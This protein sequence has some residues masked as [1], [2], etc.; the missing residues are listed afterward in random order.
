MGKHKTV[1]SACTYN[2]R[3]I[4]SQQC[5]H[6]SLKTD[7]DIETGRKNCLWLMAFVGPGSGICTAAA[8]AAA[9][10]SPSPPPPLTPPPP[11]PIRPVSCG[12]NE[13]DTDLTFLSKSR[14]DPPPPPLPA[15]E[16]E[17]GG[18]SAGAKEK[19]LSARESVIRKRFR[20][21]M[22]LFDAAWLVVRWC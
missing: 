18:V 2:A 21:L 8:A 12:P 9:D 11:D 19:V 4:S 5:R 16:G 1:V 7:D 14:P 22:L 6:L 17:M 20:S 13:S 15:G 3:R 10:V